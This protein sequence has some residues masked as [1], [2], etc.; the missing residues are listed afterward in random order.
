MFCYIA[1]FIKNIL[2]VYYLKQARL[3]HTVMLAYFIYLCAFYFIYLFY[4]IFCDVTFHSV[5]LFGLHR[6]NTLLNFGLH[7]FVTGAICKSHTVCEV[8]ICSRGSL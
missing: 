8:L 7:S 3:F 1:V 4:F 5:V 2:H 6:H